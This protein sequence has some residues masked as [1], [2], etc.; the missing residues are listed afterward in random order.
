[1]TDDQKEWADAMLNVISLKPRR[2]PPEPKDDVNRA[3]VY[4]IISNKLFEPLVLG[5]RLGWN[6]DENR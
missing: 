3:R 4:R 6:P 1:M 5:A 2:Y